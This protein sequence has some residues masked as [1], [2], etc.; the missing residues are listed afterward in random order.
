[1]NAPF[2]PDNAERAPGR[3]TL[4]NPFYEQPAN[5]SQD[6]V[7]T[8][9]GFTMYGP[10]V[11]K[12]VRERFD[13]ITAGLLRKYGLRAFEMPKRAAAIHE[14]GHVIINS[15]LGVRTTCVAI[16][17]ITRNGK[18]FW[19]GITNAPELA[20]A[21]TPAT[22]VGFDEF[23]ARSRT[24]YAG[25]AAEILFAGDD[26]RDGSSL[27]EVLMSQILAEHAAM[28]AG[29]DAPRLW[30]EEVAAWCSNQLQRNR[31]THAEITAALMKRKRLKGKVLRALCAKVAQLLS[32]DE[33]WPDIHDHTSQLIDAGIHFED[34]AGWA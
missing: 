30:F 21:D 15:V 31:K 26:R 14:A 22:P 34:A 27:D 2:T 33:V 19:I 28:L 6:D 29:L 17:H 7:F 25:I 8:L 32:P 20:F 4:I 18:L 13:A 10:G 11:G 5:L 23:L 12:A 24:T 3:A 16:D 1:M 9:A